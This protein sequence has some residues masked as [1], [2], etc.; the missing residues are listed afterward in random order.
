MSCLYLDATRTHLS[1]GIEHDGCLHTWDGSQDRH[2]K[3]LLTA[4]DELCNKLQIKLSA[5]SHC[6]V[7][8]GPGSFTGLR[9]IVSC[10]HALDLV[11]PLS[12]LPIDQLSLL[13]EASGDGL[14]AVLDARMDELYLGSRLSETGVY[15]TLSLVKATRLDDGI[16]R[17]CHES[18]RNK[19]SGE[20]VAV[21]PTLSILR[22]L[23]ARQPMTAW[24]PGRQLTPNYVRET[25]SWKPLAEQ[26]SK[27]Y[28]R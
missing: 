23:A 8:N 3:V 9:I 4:I 5:F 11:R 25:V 12:V 26:P 24:I 15:Q 22:R 10:I 17:I 6:V 20:L 19:L 16:R 7:V 1:L 21:R 2:D 28:D 13:A 27:L 18:E 14:D